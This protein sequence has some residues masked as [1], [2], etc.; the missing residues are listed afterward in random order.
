MTEGDPLAGFSVY[1]TST[2]DWRS[3]TLCYQH[4]IEQPLN[5]SVNIDC[6]GY[7]RYVTLYNS[8]NQTNAPRL[9]E[10]AYINVC[11]IH[12]AGNQLFILWQISHWSL[13]IS[14][15][16][17]NYLSKILCIFWT[18][19]DIGFYGDNCT[20]CPENCLD[21]Q[22]QFQIGHCFDCK[23]GFKG[24]T[25]DEGMKIYWRLMFAN[26]LLLLLQN[27]THFPQSDSF[28]TLFIVALL[29]SLN[30]FYAIE[31]SVLTQGVEILI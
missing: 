18:G 27:Y 8:R 14:S 4:D 13:A 22:C 7:G 11:E 9:S 10:F 3:G 17:L 28:V 19:C 1:V 6:V 29:S 15:N 5:N 30:K 16:W 26:L 31:S 2:P 23:D 20:R 21:E 12:I 25:C 24:D